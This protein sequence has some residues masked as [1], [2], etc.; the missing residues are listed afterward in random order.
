MRLNCPDA[1]TL[2]LIIRRQVTGPMD[3]TSIAISK[4]RRYTAID[5]KVRLVVN[6]PWIIRETPD[7]TVVEGRVFWRK[8]TTPSS[9]SSAKLARRPR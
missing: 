4:P 1:S 5:E 2:V 7:D 3:D 6:S 8:I 9:G